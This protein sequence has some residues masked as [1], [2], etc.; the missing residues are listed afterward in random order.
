MKDKG[1]VVQLVGIAF[2]A[3]A[4]L[5][6]LLIF[7]GGFKTKELQI[8]PVAF[9]VPTDQPLPQQAS[10]G[11]SSGSA[12]TCTGDGDIPPLPSAP[13][14]GCILIA[15]W[16]IPPD[17]SNCGI[18]VTRSQPDISTDAVGTWWYV[19]PNRPDSHI[20]EYQQKY[21]QCRV[22]DLR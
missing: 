14:S 21:P 9:E 7:L 20:K 3:G 19:Y 8:G 15:E 12:T 4:V 17:A 18:L 2:V 16:W 6:A 13:P 5:T 10:P 11:G 22:D 1:F